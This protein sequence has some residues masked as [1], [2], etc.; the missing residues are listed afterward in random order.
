MA[1]TT[2]RQVPVFKCFYPLPREELLNKDSSDFLQGKTSNYLVSVESFEI[3]P[4]GRK[5][6]NGLAVAY[7]ETYPAQL[8]GKVSFEDWARALESIND[9]LITRWPCLPCEWVSWILMPFT[10]GISLLL[11]Y[12][13]ISGAL[14]GLK[15]QL[16]Y[17][18]N[19]KAFRDAGVQIA[20][21]QKCCS[22]SLIVYC[23]NEPIPD[24]A[25]RAGSPLQQ[26]M[27]RQL[28]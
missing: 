7:D 14:N 2:N 25:S 15:S 5:A 10:L 18:N 19:K 9:G 11:A 24:D 21:K 17:I 22:S 20:Y 28:P 13:Q 16:A 4:V 1:A 23:F 27:S 26:G 8:D 3:K 6:F 12:A